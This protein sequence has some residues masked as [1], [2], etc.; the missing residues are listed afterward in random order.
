MKLLQISEAGH[1][2]RPDTFYGTAVYE[3]GE[4]I[5][6]APFKSKEEALRYVEWEMKAF[7]LEEEHRADVISIEP[8]GW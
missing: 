4:F 6:T 2:R 7:D 1:A 5:I 8:P 3:D